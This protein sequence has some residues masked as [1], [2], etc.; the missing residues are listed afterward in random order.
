MFGTHVMENTLKGLRIKSPMMTEH[1]QLAVVLFAD[2]AGYTELMQKN[3]SVALNVLER[4]KK[5]LFDSVKNHEGEI[6]Q[7]FGDGCL[8]VFNNA[9]N[10]VSSAK[11]IQEN[12]RGEP[13][14]PVR[15]GIHLG[16]VLYRE[17][18]IFGDC[19]NI[20]SRIESMGVPGAILFSDAV[21][22]QIRNKPEFQ[23]T[24]LGSF[25]FKNVEEPMEI[26]ALANKGFS[27][28]SPEKLVGKFKDGKAIKS[29]AVLP[30]LNMSNDPE[31]EYFSDGI[32]EEIL[33]S[34]AHIKGLKVAG[35]LSSLQF[36]GKNVEVKEV[37]EKLSVRTVLQGSVRK[38]G[39]RV[40]ITTQLINV[41]DGYH[42]WSERYDRELNDIFSMQE[43]IALAVT[44]ALSLTLLEKDR[45]MITRNHTQNP[46]A[47]E[48][49]LKGLFNI[50]KRGAHIFTSIQ[51]FQKAIE[52]DP[53]FALAYSLNADAHLLIATYGLM[54]P[55]QVMGKAKEL[56]EAA[57][58]LNP[59]LCEPYHALGFYYTCIEWKWAEAKKN[60]LRS[61][62]LNPKYAEAHYR[63]AWNYLIWVEGDFHKAQH[64]GEIAVLH[65]PL[66]SICHATYSL[67]LSA[68]GNFKEAT[69]ACSMGIELEP[70][71]F[72]CLMSKGN[73]HS[74]LQQYDEAI[75]ACKAAMAVSNRHHFAVNGLIWNY[76]QTGRIEEAKQLMHE[77]KERSAKEYI[78]ATFTGISAAYLGNYDEAFAFFEKAMEDRDPI[79]L[80]LKYLKWLPAS[81]RE[82]ARFQNLL[83]RI[84]FPN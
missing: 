45:E 48:L 28:P 35:R 15:I 29:I 25:E 21:K 60:F 82:D 32:A 34:L 57:I 74:S 33:N 53:D 71:S 17:G 31:Q 4:F 9:V 6:I 27:I 19:V 13:M 83:D 56:A 59:G 70:H 38:Q 36:K 78:A 26:F 77:L 68:A 51:F 49:Y 18:N 10:A 14:V 24:S 73:L 43:E 1:R 7:Y 37:G 23:L 22:K 84:G 16:D 42:L 79:I 40:R 50:N 66:S 52:L 69:N 65:E 58:T 76:C 80:T 8:M 46:A 67:I 72:L 44:D 62:Q 41:A 30:F 55:K 5:E 39:N 81:L 64:H 3:E 54:P 75:E 47:Y 2:I 12:L 11:I 61:I 63:Y 20:A